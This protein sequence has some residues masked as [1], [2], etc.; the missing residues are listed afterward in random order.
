MKMEMKNLATSTNSDV[1]TVS[2]RNRSIYDRF[3]NFAKNVF[4]VIA[5]IGIILYLII[6]HKMQV[7]IRELQKTILKPSAHYVYGISNCKIYALSSND[8]RLYIF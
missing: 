6:N 7:K 2:K 3:Y 8:A 5:I 4:Y 1:P